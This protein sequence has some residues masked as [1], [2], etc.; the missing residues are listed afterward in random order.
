M[1]SAL[2]HR[3]QL[4][5]HEDLCLSAL[6]QTKEWHEM[7]TAIS[8]STE[9]EQG[10]LTHA[11]AMAMVVFPLRRLSPASGPVPAPSENSQTLLD[12]SPQIFRLDELDAGDR[13]SVV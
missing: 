4:D 9:V 1:K 6:I 2:S 7:S 10:D 5:L 11:K 3:R 13:K 12:L 8:G